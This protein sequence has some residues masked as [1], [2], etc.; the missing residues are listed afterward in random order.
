M[1]LAA[2]APIATLF[3]TAL[4]VGGAFMGMQSQQAQANYNAQV[5]RNNQTIADQNAA[6]ARQAA[7]IKEQSA[8]MKYAGLEGSQRAQA[9]SNGFDV[10]GGSNLDILGS[11]AALGDLDAL[12]I[13]ANGERE[14]YGYRTQSSNFAGQAAAYDAAGANAGTAGIFSMGSN[15]MAGAS[16]LT[17]QQ[18]KFKQAGIK[19]LFD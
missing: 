12:T 10:N 18:F 17:N 5:A 4:S 11:T 3:G 13:R 1:G 16:A 9:A 14:A 15:I 6:Y 7:A 8:R 2:A 19:G